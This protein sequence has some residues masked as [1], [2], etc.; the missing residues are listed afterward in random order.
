[1]HTQKFQYNERKKIPTQKWKKIPVKSSI[2]SLNIYHYQDG[3]GIEHVTLQCIYCQMSIQQF[4]SQRHYVQRTNQFYCLL[5][6]FRHLATLKNGKFLDFTKLCIWFVKNFDLSIATPSAKKQK[7]RKTNW[8]ASYSKM[9]SKSDGS[10]ASNLATY[11][12][13]SKQH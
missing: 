2:I 5:S 11:C 1:M 8:N 4:Y 10:N 13:F 3:I 7:P 6:F 9:S 12:W